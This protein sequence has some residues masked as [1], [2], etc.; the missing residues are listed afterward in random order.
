MLA[1]QYLNNHERNASLTNE[2]QCT[3]MADEGQCLCDSTYLFSK[4]KSSKQSGEEETKYNDVSLH[5]LMDTSSDSEETRE[6]DCKLKDNQSNQDA[7]LSA[8]ANEENQN[9]EKFDLMTAEE[10]RKY[11]IN[12]LESQRYASSLENEGDIIV[13]NKLYETTKEVECEDDKHEV[14]NKFY[15]K[16]EE[17]EE[18]NR[19]YEIENK[20]YDKVKYD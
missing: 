17:I 13:E 1:L 4:D 2:D 15:E 8:V 6:N 18:E 10:T 20:F 12:F 7:K 16:T 9:H 3:D 11:T 19:R 14:E 5:K